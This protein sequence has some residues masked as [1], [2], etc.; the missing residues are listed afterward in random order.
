VGLYKERTSSVWWCRF[1]VAG[2]KIRR[3]TG[4]TGRREAAAEERRIR[5]KYERQASRRRGKIGDLAELAGWDVERAAANGATAKH[6]IVIEERWNKIIS[7]F[8]PCRPEAVT[9]SRIM[10]YMAQRRA[11]GAKDVLRRELSDLKRGL[12]EAKKRGWLTDIPEFPKVRTVAGDT[13][14]KGKFHE[15]EIIR[16]WLNELAEPAKGQATVVF[17]T[18][19]RATEVRRLCVTWLEGDTLR[20]PEYGT[21]GRVER[22]GRVPPMAL[23]AILRRAEQIPDGP[24]WPADHK[25]AFAGAAKR[26]GYNRSISLRDLRHTYG[27]L[28]N[29]MVGIDAAMDGLGHSSLTMTQKYISS[30]TER[31]A[32]A[33]AAIEN[34]LTQS[35]QI[36]T[37]RCDRMAALERAMGFEP[38]TLSLEGWPHEV[39]EHLSDCDHCKLLVLSR[40][41]PHQIEGDLD[42]QSGQMKKVIK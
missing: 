42:R 4:K 30:D 21:K 2:Q 17:L 32:A 41:Y 12:R 15:P 22:T 36:K 3:S 8:G 7:W 33:G 40:A 35:G 31:V 5:A 39:L 11:D 26:I 27:T 20:L 13:K 16:A 34:S 28:A 14:R 37:D 23:Q 29:R 24:L 19:L 1:T 25:K 6:Q 9:S 10:Q 38:T 18:G